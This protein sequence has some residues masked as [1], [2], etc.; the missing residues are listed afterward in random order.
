MQFNFNEKDTFTIATYNIYGWGNPNLETINEKLESINADLVGL[1]E[2]N[3]Q[4]SGNG[5]VD[6]LAKI[7]S[8]PYSAFKAGYGNDVVWGGS[9]IV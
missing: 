3:W 7:G 5:Q 6:R 8:F 9:A 4:P 2:A 1:Q